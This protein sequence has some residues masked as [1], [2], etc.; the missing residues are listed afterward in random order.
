MNETLR[1]Q[2]GDRR[3]QRPEVYPLPQWGEVLA[4]RERSRVQRPE[5]QEGNGEETAGRWG[6]QTE[7]Q[8]SK[9]EA[10]P[11]WVWKRCH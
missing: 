6:R 9:E 11:H 2:T 10:T 4:E 7:T 3:G 1:G 5:I 8:V